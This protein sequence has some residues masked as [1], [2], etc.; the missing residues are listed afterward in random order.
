MMIGYP[1]KN[2]EKLEIKLTGIKNIKNMSYMF[3]WCPS[4][5][6]LPDISGKY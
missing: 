2:D 1:N 4:L 6:S 3:F 5:S